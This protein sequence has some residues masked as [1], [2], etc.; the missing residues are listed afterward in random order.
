[1]P[2]GILTIED[3]AQLG[4]NQTVLLPKVNTLS[5]QTPTMDGEQAPP[6]RSSAGISIQYWDWEVFGQ[7]L[8]PSQHLEEMPA[9]IPIRSA[10]ERRPS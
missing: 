8:S 1:M 3:T 4:R 5:A 7:K 2:E 6:E 9:L 10:A